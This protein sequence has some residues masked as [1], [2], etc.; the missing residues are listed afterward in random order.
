[1]DSPSPTH[2]LDLDQLTWTEYMAAGEDIFNSDFFIEYGQGTNFRK[3]YSQ[4]EYSKQYGNCLCTGYGPLIATGM[5]FSKEFSPD[6]RLQMVKDRSSQADFE[7]TVGWFTS[8]GVDVNRRLYNK[9]FPSD[10][11]VSALVND[12]GLLH[13]LYGK[14]IPVVTSL[15]GNKQYTL[16][17]RDGIMQELNYWTFPGARYGHCRTRMGLEMFDNYLNTYKYLSWDALD[18]CMQHAFESKN[19]F[20]FFKESSLSEFG[21][22]LLKAMRRGLINW[23][24]LPDKLIRSESG[25]IGHRWDNVP[26]K[27]VW[28]GKDGS[29]NVSKYELSVMMNRGSH[30]LIPIYLGT[31]R[32]QEITRKAAIEYIGPY[33]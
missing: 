21:K 32:N 9:T 28:N 1:M 10:P 19:V 13:K 12:I 23:E 20:M 25:A 29:K 7:P 11:I 3:Q 26:D 17:T 16:D 27:D 5:M 6:Y 2:L 15:K 8:I 14:N 22:T 18:L 4:L 30:G 31:D 33:L 24:R